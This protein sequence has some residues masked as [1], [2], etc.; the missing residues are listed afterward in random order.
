MTL[1]LSQSKATPSDGTRPLLAAAALVA[2]V[3]TVGSLYFSLGLG[4]T[5]CTLCWYQRILMYPLVVVVGVATLEDRPGV[6]RTALPL[7]VPG[8]ALALYHSYLQVA[9]APSTQC[10]LD[11]SCVAVQYPMFGGLLTIPRLSLVAFVLVSVVLAIVALR[12]R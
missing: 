8:A 9:P 6:F 2:A 11:Q 4:L 7:S 12:T 3:A 10:S 1:G 5:P